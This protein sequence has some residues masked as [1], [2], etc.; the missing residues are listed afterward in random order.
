[1]QPVDVFTP[2]AP[3]VLGQAPV[4]PRLFEKVWLVCLPGEEPIGPVSA[5]QLA[6][7]V[8]AG[9]VPSDARVK[10][11]GDTFWSDLLDLPDFILALKAVSA[12]SAPPPPP[13]SLA[14]STRRDAVR[15]N[16]KRSV[17]EVMAQSS[18]GPA[19]AEATR[20]MRRS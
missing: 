7:G 16:S 19:A 6:R 9:K 15:A 11:V 20:R 5:D 8:R 12:E 17:P 13:P 14:I 10:H 2:L 18:S 3:P 1:M 4:E